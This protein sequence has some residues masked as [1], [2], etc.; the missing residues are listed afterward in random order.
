MSYP[1]YYYYRKPFD[2]TLGIL[3]V[4][5]IALIVIACWY[6]WAAYI[7]RYSPD[8]IAGKLLGKYTKEI[9]DN[10]QALLADNGS[11]A[12]KPDG[13]LV[14]SAV[15]TIRNKGIDVVAQSQ[16][17]FSLPVRDNCSPIDKTCVAL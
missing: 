10:T 6:Y 17:I 11:L 14:A 15:M 12:S 9:D 2:W 1:N 8:R 7:N 3:I 16:E 13:S 5:G 4:L